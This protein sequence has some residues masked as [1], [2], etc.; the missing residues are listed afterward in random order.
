MGIIDKYST[1]LGI[2]WSAGCRVAI[3]LI[4]DL[5]SSVTKPTVGA[6]NEPE[7]GF[8]TGQSAKYKSPIGHG[9][10]SQDGSHLA[11]PLCP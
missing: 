10:N 6:G 8:L 1:I 5:N 7:S 4:G 2:I 11:Q 9:P 3:M